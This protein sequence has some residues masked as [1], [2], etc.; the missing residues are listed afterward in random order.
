MVAN[1]EL[2]ALCDMAIRA[3]AVL[4][5]THDERALREE[6]STI[7][8][9]VQV[10]GI[11]GIGPHPMSSIF[12]AEMLRQAKFEGKLA[13]VIVSAHITAMPK[14]LLSPMPQ[15]FAKTSDGQEHKLFS[16]YPDEI[17]FEPHEFVGLTVQEAKQLRFKKDVQYLQGEAL[18]RARV[19]RP[20]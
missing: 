4:R 11:P 15:V 20:G 17:S 16:F 2:K 10:V 7:I 19:D 6:G 1:D 12:A 14:T 13:P 9:T 8:E 18:A 5:I 3:G